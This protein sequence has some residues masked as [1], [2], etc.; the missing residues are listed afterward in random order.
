MKEFCEMC[1]D[2]AYREVET[3]DGII[4]M[5]KGCHN[6]YMKFDMKDDPLS[7][8][9]NYMMNNAYG[10]ALSLNEI[11]EEFSLTRGELL[12]KMHILNKERGMPIRLSFDIK[13]GSQSKKTICMICR[14]KQGIF[15]AIEID[16][17]KKNLSGIFIC[18]SCYRD[19]DKFEKF[20]KDL[21][22][23]KA[24]KKQEKYIKDLE[25]NR[26]KKISEED[27]VI[28]PACKNKTLLWFPDSNF[29]YCTNI[30]CAKRFKKK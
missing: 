6:S 8:L 26:D 27:L 3:P 9:Y 29:G 11:M 23:K 20:V 17:K 30:K 7:E 16:I 24:R 1:G 28:C 4:T 18:N 19:K 10:K 22:A 2:K 15:R 21:K 25:I 5:C 13:K 14:R 12:E